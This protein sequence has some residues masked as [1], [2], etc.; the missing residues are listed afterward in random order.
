M[1]YRLRRVG[2]AI[3]PQMPRVSIHVPIYTHRLTEHMSIH[4][5]I[6]I[7]ILLSMHMSRHMSIH[8]AVLL[9]DQHMPGQSQM[10]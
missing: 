10:P 8:N 2:N 1:P 3:G 4:G 5:S 6:C 9:D 7:D